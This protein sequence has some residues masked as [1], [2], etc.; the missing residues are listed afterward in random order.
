LLRILLFLF[1]WPLLSYSQNKVAISVQPKDSWV[2][3]NSVVV[4]N[5]TVQ[6]FEDTNFHIQ[7][8]A[9]NYLPIDSTFDIKSNRRFFR[10]EVK[11]NRTQDFKKFSNNRV[12]RRGLI[13]IP[14]VS[15]PLLLASVQEYQEPGVDIK[16]KKILEQANIYFSEAEYHKSVIE[17]SVDPNK[18]VV[19]KEE[20]PRQY[21]L[22]LDALED[23]NKKMQTYSDFVTEE[24]K[25]VRFRNGMKIGFSAAIF[26]TSVVALILNKKV[27]KP[28]SKN[29]F[30]NNSQMGFFIDNNAN[31]ISYKLKF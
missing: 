31:G 25:K 12:F 27:Y 3:F 26:A 28:K 7:S 29:P 23:Y 14:L 4:P 8:W 6:D 16:T 13:I 5:R 30:I 10:Y 15:I 19:S 20:F 2:L 24:E 18:I 22:Y 1:L 9:E 21:Q 17:T 11:M